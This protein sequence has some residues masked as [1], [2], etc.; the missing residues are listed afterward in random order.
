MGGG[1]FWRPEAAAAALAVFLLAAL[2]LAAAGWE[3]SAGVSDDALRSFA[4]EIALTFQEGAIEAGLLANSDEIIIPFAFRPRWWGAGAVLGLDFRHGW[5]LLAHIEARLECVIKEGG[6][7]ATTLRLELGAQGGLGS[8]YRKQVPL[9]YY[10]PRWLAGIRQDLGPL[11]F[12]IDF[13]GHDRFRADQ[14][15]GPMLHGR[16]A[17]QAGPHAEIGAYWS[18]VFA[19]G[20]NELA[21]IRARRGGLLCVIKGF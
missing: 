18:L 5:D 4:P 12:E 2:P 11:A 20:L 10:A 19:N 14:L 13:A 15:L 17:F 9:L 16:V 3:V 1:G 8:T 6:A 21:Y 7:L